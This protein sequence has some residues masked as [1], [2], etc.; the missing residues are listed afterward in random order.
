MIKFYKKSDNLF[1][2]GNAVIPSL[3]YFCN[4]DENAGAVS[5]IPIND[6]DKLPEYLNLSVEKFC[7]EAGAPYSSVDDIY[8]ILTDFFVNASLLSGGTIDGYIKFGSD[9][10]AIKMKKVSMTTNDVGGTYLY[11]TGIS[12]SKIVS[13]TIFV[14]A[15]NNELVSP[16]SFNEASSYYYHAFINSEGNIGLYLPETASSVANRPFTAL[17]TYEE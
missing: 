10:P 5:L 16:N 6:N 8:N 4:I 17:I 2:L 1:V 11:S 7:D 9:A 3:L 12:K 15:S 13:F 14:N